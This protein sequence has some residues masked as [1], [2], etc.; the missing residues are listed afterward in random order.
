MNDVFMEGKSLIHNLFKN[1]RSF[2]IDFKWALMKAY[3]QTFQ[4]LL[5]ELDFHHSLLRVVLAELDDIES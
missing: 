5:P 3:C 2:I 1:L 4:R